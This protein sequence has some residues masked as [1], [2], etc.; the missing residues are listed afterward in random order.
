MGYSMMQTTQTTQSSSATA[1]VAPEYDM[2]A[3]AHGSGRD[4]ASL[5][6]Q[7]GE[8]NPE[9]AKRILESSLGNLSAKDVARICSYISESLE[10]TESKKKD[11]AQDAAIR[12]DTGLQVKSGLSQAASEIDPLSKEVERLG[13]KLR[14]A[15]EEAE[16]VQRDLRDAEAKIIDA[17]AKIKEGI[18]KERKAEREEEKNAKEEATRLRELID[19]ALKKDPSALIRALQGAVESL[20]PEGTKKISQ[21][22]AP[23]TI[24]LLERFLPIERVSLQAA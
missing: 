10:K 12:S 19:E 11:A 20:S 8:L 18:A 3:P 15:P 14:D 13:A 24:A 9:E 6:R 21:E 1:I 17:E 4:N 23:S 5:Q 16:V 22:V 7:I 2:N